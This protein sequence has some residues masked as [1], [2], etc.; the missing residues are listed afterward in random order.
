MSRKIEMHFESD[1]KG[2]HMKGRIGLFVLAGVVLA[3][4]ALGRRLPGE[5]TAVGTI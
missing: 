3:G 2:E 1:K 5:E 4:S